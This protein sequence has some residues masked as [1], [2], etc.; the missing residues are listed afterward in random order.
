MRTPLIIFA[1]ALIVTSP[2]AAWAGGKA[3]GAE[4]GG[5]VSSEGHFTNVTAF[6]PTHKPAAPPTYTNKGNAGNRHHSHIIVVGSRGGGGWSRSLL[7]S[8]SSAVGEHGT[9]QPQRAW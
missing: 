1:A 4:T 9:G 7:G 3:G 5:S 6:S 8:V 2:S